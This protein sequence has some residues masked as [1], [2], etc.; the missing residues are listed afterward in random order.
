[1]TIGAFM[2]QLQRPVIGV[3]NIIEVRFMTAEAVRGQTG[4]CLPG[5]VTGRTHQICVG[6]EQ[7]EAEDVVV[8][9]RWPPG[10]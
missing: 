5:G 6:S 9:T 10:H 2:R 8:E 3:S 7:D 1:M 4:I